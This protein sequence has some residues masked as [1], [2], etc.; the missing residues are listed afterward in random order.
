MFAT[1]NK[2]PTKKQ[3]KEINP[4]TMAEVRSV[5]ERPESFTDLLPYM[6]Y[7]NHEQTFELEDGVSVA[8]VFEIQ[9]IGSEARPDDPNIPDNIGDGPVHYFRYC[10]NGTCVEVVWDPPWTTARISERGRRI[11]EEAGI[12]LIT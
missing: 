9:P 11:L 1:K 5:Y 10:E 7:S 12:A 8:A 2:K 4:I 6:G 3:E